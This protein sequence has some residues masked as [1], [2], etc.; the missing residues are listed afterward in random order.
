M[1][2][3][4]GF[5]QFKRFYEEAMEE[6]TQQHVG[7]ITKAEFLV[8]IADPFEHAFTP[9]NIKKGFEKDWHMAYQS[10]K[11]YTRDDSPI[12]WPIGQGQA[13]HQSQQ[14]SKE[15]ITAH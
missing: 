6:H 11:D 4:V 9:E 12:G 3:V 15:H 5:S 13:H 10:K 7:K 8:A 14:P 1:L 2:D